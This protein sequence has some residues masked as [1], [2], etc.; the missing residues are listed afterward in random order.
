MSETALRGAWN[1]LEWHAELISPRPKGLQGA[2]RIEDF[3]KS[4][5]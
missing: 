4:A 5:S 2:F 3:E 1:F